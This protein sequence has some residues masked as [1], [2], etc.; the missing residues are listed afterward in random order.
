MDLK[1]KLEVKESRSARK[2]SNMQE[3]FKKNNGENRGKAPP[4]Y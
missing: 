1:T 4:C 3:V 2:V